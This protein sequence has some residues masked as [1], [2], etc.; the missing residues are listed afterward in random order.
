MPQY[1][2]F[3]PEDAAVFANDHS[4]LFGVHSKLTSVSFG[5]NHMNQVF[6]VK[7][8]FGT[9]LIVKQALPV[10][11]GLSEQWPLSLDRLRIEAE[12]LRQLAKAAPAHVVEVLHYD[13]EQAAMLLEDLDQYELLSKTL[14]S[15]RQFH[16]LGEQLAELLAHNSFFSSDFASD[17]AGKNVALQKFNNPEAQQVV[18]DLLL[19]DPYINHDRNQHQPHLQQLARQLWQDEKL[20]AEV[21]SLKAAYRS[22]PQAL[23][24][25]DLGLTS[26][27]VCGDNIKVIDAEFACYG[28]VGFDLGILFGSL[29]LQYCAAPGVI[30]EAQQAR[31]QQN[32]LHNQLKNCWQH[33]STTFL[34]LCQQHCRDPLLSSSSY[35]E[36]FV[37]QVLRYS[38]GYA[39]AELIRRVVGAFP[40]AEFK[41]ITNTTAKHQAQQHAIALGC[42]LIMLHA[43]ATSITQL[44]STLQDVQIQ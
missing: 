3:T 11:R 21:A 18:E 16:Q 8:Q 32:Y 13:H 36:K 30:N 15:G 41:Q 1:H 20:Q 4:E 40:A 43:E 37:L 38:L 2:R 22:C 26:I 19:S 14:A 39:G 17:I 35:Q 10:A 27:F 33:F 5:E 24:H 6:R 23:Q 12:T 31:D 25:G 9:S 34:A 44:L 7:N 29:M 28:P 42:R